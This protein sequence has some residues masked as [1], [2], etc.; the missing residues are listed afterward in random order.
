MKTKRANRAVSTV[1]SEMLILSIVVILASAFAVSLQSNVSYYVKNK[2][3]SSIYLSTSTKGPWVNFTATHSGGDPTTISGHI[4]IE[5]QN[6]S[7]S[8]LNALLTYNNV[9]TTRT[10]DFTLQSVK[11]GEQFQLCVNITNFTQGTIHCLLNSKTQILA[12]VTEEIEA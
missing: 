7:S 6:G 3:L 1:I 11:F 9:T 4:Y 10:G 2:E 8:N 12:E 5:Y